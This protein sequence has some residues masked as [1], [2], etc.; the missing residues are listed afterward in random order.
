MM[1]FDDGADGR[2]RR[3]KLLTMMR[4]LLNI[5]LTTDGHER[6]LTPRA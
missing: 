4:H 6:R 2:R 3:A 1:E 5:L